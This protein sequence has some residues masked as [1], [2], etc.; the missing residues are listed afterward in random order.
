MIL[1]VTWVTVIGR[2]MIVRLKVSV[3]ITITLV[4]LLVILLDSD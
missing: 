3:P 2:N 4:L 1:I